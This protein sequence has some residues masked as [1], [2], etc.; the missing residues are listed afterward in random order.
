RLLLVG[1]L[2]HG[3]RWPR[4]GCVM[5]CRKQ[6]DLRL[7]LAGQVQ[8]GFASILGR[9]AAAGNDDW[10]WQLGN[11]RRRCHGHRGKK[12]R[13][14]QDANGHRIVSKNQSESDEPTSRIVAS[15]RCL[16]T[17]GLIRAAAFLNL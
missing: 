7:V 15:K 5:L 6:Y 4:F 10:P 17:A 1:E 3:R 12:G 16:Q 2:Q 14:E 9:F 13:Q 11:G 8:E